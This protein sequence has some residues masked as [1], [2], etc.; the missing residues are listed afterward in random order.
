[1]TVFADVKDDRPKTTFDSEMADV[2]QKLSPAIAMAENIAKEQAARKIDDEIKMSTNLVPAILNFAYMSS[3]NREECIALWKDI[4]KELKSQYLIIHEGDLLRVFNG[5]I[6]L[7][8]TVS[9][10][11]FNPELATKAN[12]AINCLKKPPLTDILEYELNIK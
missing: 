11:T 4:F 5:T 6:D 8:K 10:V 1:M 12:L 3:E 2:A 9:E 7:L